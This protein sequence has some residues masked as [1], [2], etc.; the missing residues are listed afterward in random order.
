MNIF[1]N[2]K[3]INFISNLDYLF[4]GMVSIF[5]VIGII[6]IVTIVLNKLFSN[7]K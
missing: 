5:L 1:E 4:V 3:P 6:M 7:K 2:F